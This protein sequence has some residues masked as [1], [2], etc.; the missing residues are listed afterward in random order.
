MSA[1]TVSDWPQRLSSFGSSWT[2]QP[3]LKQLIMYQE[4]QV[5]Q[6]SPALHDLTSPYPMQV[7]PAHTELHAITAKPILTLLLLY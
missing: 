4:L 6:P 2:Q 1:T 5:Q 7:K 3:D